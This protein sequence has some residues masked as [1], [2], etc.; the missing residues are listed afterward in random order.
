MK[1]TES[2]PNCPLQIKQA[3]NQVSEFVRKA[4]DLGERSFNILDKYRDRFDDEIAEDYLLRAWMLILSILEASGNKFLLKQGLA[5]FD[6]C[7]KKP[8]ESKMGPEEPYLVWPWK[9][10]DYADLLA[11]IYVPAAA[12]TTEEVAPLIEILKRCEKYLVHPTLFAWPPCGEADVHERIEELLACN[13]PRL[14]HKP[15]LNKSI[16]NFEPDTGLPSIKTLVEYKYVSSQ[17]DARRIVEE[18][19]ADIGGYQSRD[20]VQ[21]VFLI[22]ETERFRRLDEWEDVISRSNP[23]NPVEVVLLKGV[24]PTVIDMRRANKSTKSIMPPRKKRRKA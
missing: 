24:R 11:A 7:R 17:D 15:R 9:V 20:Y 23:P 8:L 21:F 1:P 5:D 22:Y 13:Y 16:K 19:L 6:L 18:I 4:V 3:L 2:Q 10:Q 14:Q 12:K